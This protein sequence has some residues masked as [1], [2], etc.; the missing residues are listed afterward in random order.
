MDDTNRFSMIS[1]K[2]CKSRGVARSELADKV[3]AF[4]DLFDDP[5]SLC[6]QLQHGL[7]RSLPMQ[8]M[9]DK[10]YCSVSLLRDLSLAR[11][12]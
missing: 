2:S 12:V 8:L 1:F 5:Y 4:A 6:S 10:N 7:G 3:T 9:T 11:S